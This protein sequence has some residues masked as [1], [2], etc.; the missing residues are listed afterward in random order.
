MECFLLL[1]ALNAARRNS[2]VVDADQPTT[3]II[4]DPLFTVGVLAMTVNHVIARTN[5]HLSSVRKGRWLPRTAAR[6]VR[7][8]AIVETRPIRRTGRAHPAPLPQVRIGRRIRIEGHTRHTELLVPPVRAEPRIRRVVQRTRKTS[9]AVKEPIRTDPAP[10][11][12]ERR[13]R[14]IR[15]A[16]SRREAEAASD[17]VGRTD[18]P[19]P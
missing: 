14:Q 6:R 12:P 17:C 11:R 3:W 10:T 4:G 2:R 5:S 7:P 13:T 1:I 8:R 19:P 18:L 16:Q 15:I 9:G